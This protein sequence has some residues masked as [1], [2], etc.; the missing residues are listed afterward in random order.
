MKRPEVRIIEPQSEEIKPANVSKTEEEILLQK[1]GYGTSTNRPVQKYDPTQEMTAEE[2]FRMEDRR[3]EEE[4]RAREAKM[5]GP[6]PI[7]FDG[8]YN[9]D[10][11]FASGDGATFKVNIVSD[12]YIPPKNNL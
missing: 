1:Y 9:S 6:K 2:L 8:D 10:T 4:R 11:S 3:I 5:R 7:T 12:M